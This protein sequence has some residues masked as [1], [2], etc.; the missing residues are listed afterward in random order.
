MKLTKL[1]LTKWY[2]DVIPQLFNEQVKLAVLE[3][4]EILQKHLIFKQDRNIDDSIYWY[5][6]IFFYYW[7]INCGYR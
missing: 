7:I 6:M 1:N 3:E 4:G 2:T 5:S